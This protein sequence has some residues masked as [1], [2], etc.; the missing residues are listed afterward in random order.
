MSW[1]KRKADGETGA[2]LI[3]TVI[4][5]AFES[6]S[7]CVFKTSCLVNNL[8]FLF[9]RTLIREK[10]FSTEFNLDFRLVDAVLFN[11]ALLHV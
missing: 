6:R 10:L 11:L 1:N 8:N 7:T 3:N 9:T 4:T 2:H 5:F